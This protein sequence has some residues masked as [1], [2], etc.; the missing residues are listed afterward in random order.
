MNKRMYGMAPG[1][2]MSLDK[3]A[4]RRRTIWQSKQK[5]QRPERASQASRERGGKALLQEPIRR[6]AD[7]AC[8]E[9]FG[10]DDDDE[11]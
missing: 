7:A 2:R 11:G 10:V 6:L 3:V 5:S 8:V 9:W 1:G 4:N